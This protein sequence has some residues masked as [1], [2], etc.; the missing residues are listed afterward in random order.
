MSLDSFSALYEWKKYK[1]EVTSDIGKFFCVWGSS[2]LYTINIIKLIAKTVN[3]LRYQLYI[4]SMNTVIRNPRLTP[5]FN[6][7]PSVVVKLCV[8]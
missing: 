3:D 6:S 5:V 8:L 1:R 2:I 7:T 4:L